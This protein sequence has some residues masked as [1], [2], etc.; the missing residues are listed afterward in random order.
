LLTLVLMAFGPAAGQAA[1]VPG[2]E[3][4]QILS[5]DLKEN[6]FS[7]FAPDGTTLA[8]GGAGGML[9]LWDVAS[10]SVRAASPAS[11]DAFRCAAF[12]PD[13]KTLATGRASG[14]ITVW[15]A[16]GARPLKSVR[17]H[18]AGIRS[19]S[20]SP[21]GRE[22]ITCGQDR[23]LHVWDTATWAVARSLPEQPQPILSA[24]IAPGGKL[25]AI[26]LG[27]PAKEGRDGGVKLYDFATLAEQGELPGFSGVV[28]TIAF[29]PDG[30]TLAAG[31]GP[32]L[33][34][35]DPL[36]RRARATL[37]VPHTI[38]G[39]AF[40]PDGK[41]L[42][43]VGPATNRS[44]ERVEEVG[45]LCD[46]APLQPRAIL[47][48]HRQ[49]IV[50]VSFSP[51]GR[52]LS[53]A[54]LNEPAV[55]LWD[56]SKFPPPPEA[57]VAATP[58]TPNG[59]AAPSRL[60]QLPPGGLSLPGTP[61][62]HFRSV[63]AGHASDVWCSVF[64]ADGQTLAT[65][66]NDQIVRLWDPRTGAERSSLKATSALRCAVYFPGGER[67]AAGCANGAV[68]VWDV[69]QGKPVVTLKKNGDSIRTL[70]VA[71]DGKALAVG[72]NDKTL[73]LYDTASWA[74][75]HRLAPQ[76]E[77]ILGLAHSPDGQTLA[78]ATGH[79]PQGGAG[80]VKLLDA[81]SLEERTVLPFR[82]DVWAVAF[83][84]DGKLLATTSQAAPEPVQLWDLST[85]TALRALKPVGGA[86]R[87]A[88]APDGATLAVGQ[89]SGT[90][91]LF[92]PATGRLLAAFR[93]HGGPIFGLGI[94][95]DGKLLAT[96]SGD[97]TVKLW[98]LPAATE[99]G[100]G[101]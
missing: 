57:A 50:G 35:W 47:L 101:K 89:L 81:T 40:S 48:S 41:T 37:K 18:S 52:L 17:A 43:T 45:Q 97:G 38:R 83:S 24:A 62:L 46:V 87:I 79:P 2:L 86:R 39:V 9:K 93:G 20:F 69:P 31:M 67:L 85:A 15:D 8:T 74:E 16:Q 76:R 55:R 51:D 100:E 60:G 26:A 7:V 75:I 42:V 56:I 95:P 99:R 19:V 5:G 65:G 54:T 53:T 66:G 34:L 84:P 25:L 6:W 3:S 28:W 27:D 92:D 78:M 82:Y 22:L 1:D 12:A 59:N 71:P 61:P 14:T 44:S 58:P 90:I 63:I 13:G 29:A 33:W 36:T 4:T 72:G 32:S 23:V 64:A 98:D 70:A 21:D 73:I 94:S 77:P 10:E 88:F 68:Q 11:R 96:A 91:S 30:Q 80:G 49:N